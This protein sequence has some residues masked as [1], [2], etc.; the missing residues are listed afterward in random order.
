MSGCFPI[1]NMNPINELL[2]GVFGDNFFPA[3]NSGFQPID[4]P[5]LINEKLL[6]F[7]FPAN[8]KIKPVNDKTQFDL[9]GQVSSMVGQLG[10][11]FSIFGVLFL[12]LDLIRAIID[13]ICAM[14]NPEPMI[15]AMIDLFVTVLPPIIALY[16]PLS[17]IL[18]IINVIK[19][20]V[21]IVVSLLSII[22]PIFDLIVENASGIAA[23]IAE[24]SLNAVNTETA[25][26]CGLFQS[27]LN[28]LGCFDPISFI[29]EMIDFFSSLGSKLF[30]A[31]DAGCCDTTSCPPAITNPAR[32]G[33]SIISVVAG[34]TLGT[35]VPFLPEDIA[36]FPLGESSITLRDSDNNLGDLQDYILDPTQ[37]PKS[38][39][40]D[41]A[42]VRV[43]INGVAYPAK[44]ASSSANTITLKISGA[45]ADLFTVGDAVNYEVVPDTTTLLTNNLISL[46]CISE[47]RAAANTL[48]RFNLNPIVASVGIFPRPD[49]MRAAL[50]QI[51][52]DQQADPTT[53]RTQAIKDVADSYLA[54][55]ADY[56]ADVICLG[57]DRIETDF[58]VSSGFATA[59]GSSLSNLT[60][61]VKDANKVA[62]LEGGLPNAVDKFTAQFVTNFGTIGPVLFDRNTGTFQAS[63]TS[64]EVGEAQISAI[65]V[66]N[67]QERMRPGITDG[68]GIKDKGLVVDFISE[69][70]TYARRRKTR[71]YV[72]SAGGGRR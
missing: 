44:S 40:E 43:R 64:S 29:I 32:G 20:I 6:Q 10:P 51:L 50:T 55:L 24:G 8:A 52:Q 17:T 37:L 4:R 70:G 65:F 56:Y 23:L 63:I 71:Q 53:D 14:F 31:S 26:L 46:G 22:I 49:D 3:L 30:C 21:A 59:D 16:P 41:A 27:V 58:E 60:L 13:I 47:I 28:E 48:T 69:G 72:Q 68:F 7:Q 45:E 38:G 15:L 9:A 66:V 25:K 18:M 62:L 2:M 54:G 12:I 33:A 36:S 42:T 34:A 61:T 5:A 39:S 57:A 11:I 1:G 19:M 35:F 67:S